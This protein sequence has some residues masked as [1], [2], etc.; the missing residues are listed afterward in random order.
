MARFV[1]T[2]C[3]I[4]AD[5]VVPA[6]EPQELDWPGVAAL[7]APSRSYEALMTLRRMST[8][9]YVGLRMRP[10]PPGVYIPAERK[11]AVNAER[12]KL[13]VNFLFQSPDRGNEIG[14]LIK[15]SPT[16]VDDVLS[17]YRVDVALFDAKVEE[18]SSG[19]LA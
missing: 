3:R 2:P 19:E 5:H 13:P 6:G 14:W 15:R 8:N 7:L 1:L 17:V 4:R 11:E 18:L 12:K 16:F 10:L 9:A